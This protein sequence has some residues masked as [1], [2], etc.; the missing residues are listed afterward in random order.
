MN[1]DEAI[2]QVIKNFPTIREDIKTKPKA[3]FSLVGP[4]RDLLG[5]SC[6]PKEVKDRLEQYFQAKI[7]DKVKKEI[8]EYKQD[9]WQHKVTKELV[10]RMITRSEEQLNDKL[11]TSEFY[12]N[13]FKTCYIIQG[14]EFA[15]NYIKVDSPM[16]YKKLIDKKTGQEIPKVKEKFN[17]D[18]IYINLKKFELL[19]INESDVNVVELT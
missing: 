9:V 17:S 16:I 5:P 3:M 2:E 6:N 7:P 4:I 19:K 15:E 13:C 10:K 14:S 11:R 1:I 8:V 12:E 18:Y